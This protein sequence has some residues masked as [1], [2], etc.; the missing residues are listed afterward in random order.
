MNYGTLQAPRNRSRAI[1]SDAEWLHRAQEAANA[2]ET[3]RAI[4][5]DAAPEREAEIR[6]RFIGFN[7]LLGE[8]E[9]QLDRVDGTAGEKS[10]RRG[11]LNKMQKD[12]ATLQQL[13]RDKTGTTLDRTRGPAASPTERPGEEGLKTLGLGNEQLLRLQHET[14]TQQNRELDDLHTAAVRI[15]NV[16]RMIGSELVEQDR[17]LDDLAD[18]EDVVLG[19]MQRERGRMN[20]LMAENKTG[21]SLCLV[22]IL[23]AI[24]VLLILLLLGVL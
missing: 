15:K 2:L 18:R 17:L 19:Q 11:R 5:N 9:A 10:R 22:F 23:V 12:R 21:I 14:L 20:K 13:F 4:V 3:L 16:G 8:L 1:M 7:Q 6:K 24:L